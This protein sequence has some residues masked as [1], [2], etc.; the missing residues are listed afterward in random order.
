MS[1]HFV[2]KVLRSLRRCERSEA[3]D[4]K[5]NIGVCGSGG[6]PWAR[7]I[8]PQRCLL[9]LPPAVPGAG[10]GNGSDGEHHQLQ[11]TPVGPTRSK[12]AGDSGE[13]RM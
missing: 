7:P 4:W 3:C 13:G 8:P 5:P 10:A 12:V 6:A 11:C 2:L 9:L 1:D